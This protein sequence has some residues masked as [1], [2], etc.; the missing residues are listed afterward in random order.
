[1]AGPLAGWPEFYSTARYFFA[2]SRRVPDEL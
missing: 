1:M 2:R